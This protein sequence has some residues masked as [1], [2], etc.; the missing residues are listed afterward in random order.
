MQILRVFGYLVAFSLLLTGLLAGGCSVAF[1]PVMLGG[2][3]DAA[4][5][6]ILTRTDIQG[7]WIAGLVICLVCLFAGRSLIAGLKE[8][9]GQ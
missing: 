8:D 7:Y 4:E 6:G 3:V 1:I 9:A 2:E 5:L